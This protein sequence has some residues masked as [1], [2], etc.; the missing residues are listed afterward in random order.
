MTSA[1]RTV[2]VGLFV[3]GSIFSSACYTTRQIRQPTPAL[4][5]P[6][7]V[8][9]AGRTVT[10]H[11]P[12]IANDTLLL[13]WEHLAE[14]PGGAVSGERPDSSLVIVPLVQSISE[15][16]GPKTAGLVG[17]GVGGAVAAQV[18]LGLHIL[19]WGT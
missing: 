17:L 4:T 1:R 11:H 19:P 18:L 12:T 8:Q 9:V 14:R 16:D 13:G 5:D 10:L 3:A 15:V 2:E 6:M 7:E